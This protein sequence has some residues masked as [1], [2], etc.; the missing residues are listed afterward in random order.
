[1]KL[2][3]SQRPFS[4]GSSQL[5]S[6]CAVNIEGPAHDC[7]LRPR[8][9]GSKA[10]NVA[11]RKID[12]K[13]KPAGKRCQIPILQAVCETERACAELAAG[14][15]QAEVTANLAVPLSLKS[16]VAGNPGDDINQQDCSKVRDCAHTS[17][18]ATKPRY[19]HSEQL[20]YSRERAE[21]NCKEDAANSQ[22]ITDNLEH[23][24]RKESRVRVARGRIKIICWI[25]TVGPV[26]ANMKFYLMTL[27][28]CLMA[29]SALADSRT[30]LK[31]IFG[32]DYQPR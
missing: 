31:P 2:L 30:D 24:T 3:A 25:S 6:I 15:P 10:D 13:E 19:T 28:A 8:D 26:L 5:L 14:E 21:P 7:M 18:R 22:G 20:K 1:M 11:F 9:S 29:R 27:A 17:H 23:E 12:S 16:E 32:V 4:E